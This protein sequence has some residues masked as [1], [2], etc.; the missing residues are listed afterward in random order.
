VGTGSLRVLSIGCTED[1]GRIPAGAGKAHAETIIDVFMIGQSRAAIGTAKL[2]TGHM[3]GKH[4]VYRYQEVV[5]KG[6]YALDSARQVQELRGL[7]TSLARQALQEILPVFFESH[8]EPFVP[9]H[10]K[11]QE[12]PPTRQEGP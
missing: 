12:P 1:L 9:V 5:P 11:S 10:G 6:T 3:S 8:R 4:R 2:L 7:G